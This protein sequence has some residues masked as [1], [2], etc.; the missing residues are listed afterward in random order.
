MSSAGNKEAETGRCWD[1]EMSSTE[2]KISIAGSQEDII[3]EI[4]G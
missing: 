1:L 4:L 2:D 3:L